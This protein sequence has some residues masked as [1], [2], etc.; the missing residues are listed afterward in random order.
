VCRLKK[1]QSQKTLF[2]EMTAALLPRPVFVVPMAMLCTRQELAGTNCGAYVGAAE[3]EQ[4]GCA[5][6]RME[7][8]G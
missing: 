8:N 5:L 3:V 1:R 4:L 2:E 7:W 6:A